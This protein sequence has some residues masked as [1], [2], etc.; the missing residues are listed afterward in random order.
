VLESKITQP[1]WSIGTTTGRSGPPTSFRLG[2]DMR[3][4]LRLGR[5]VAII[6]ATT[7]SQRN[8][9][10]GVGRRGGS[11]CLEVATISERAGRSHGLLWMSWK[12]P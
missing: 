6:S 2:S 8:C 11:G 3:P 12:C 9:R 7:R 10:N 1:S 4:T 5:L